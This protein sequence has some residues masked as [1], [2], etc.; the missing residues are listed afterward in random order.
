MQNMTIQHNIQLNIAEISIR[1]GYGRVVSELNLFL[2]GS[3]EH[4]QSL[5]KLD[6]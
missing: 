6:S 1:M 3:E 4:D 5:S 2:L